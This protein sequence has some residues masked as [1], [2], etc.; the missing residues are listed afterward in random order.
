M[1]HH[2]AKGSPAAPLGGRTVHRRHNGLK[3]AVLLGGLSALILV[4]GSFFGRRPDRRRSSSRSA[5][6]RTPTGTATSWR[7]APCAPARSANS[8]RPQLYRIVRELSTAARQ[9][10]PRL[11][12]SPDPGTQ[13][14]RHRPQPAQRRGVL[15]RGHP[16]DPR[17][18]RAARRHRP[19]AEPRLQPRHPHLVRRGRARLGGDVP[20]RTSPGSSPSAAPTTTRAPASSACCWS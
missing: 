2:H 1:E 10:M 11:Y 8:R 16:A 18:A 17:R 14:L 3:T 20:G 6:T 19:R 9:P 5:P 13:R 4:I 7:C 15:H 12:I